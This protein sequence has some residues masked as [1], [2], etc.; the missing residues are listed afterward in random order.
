MCVADADARKDIMSTNLKFEIH[1][2]NN[3]AQP[4]YWKIIGRNGYDTLAKS[5][6]LTS[7]DHTLRMAQFVKASAMSLL[8]Q[9]FR[10][11][12]GPQP[13]TWRV[14]AANNHVVVSASETYA[15]QAGAQAAADS[16]KYHASAAEIVDKTRSAVASR[17]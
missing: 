9:V 16:V 11:N 15:N 10:S 8:F 4:Y 13:W 5:E 2:S 17:W 7:K 6:T 14:L 12:N 1:D 3:P